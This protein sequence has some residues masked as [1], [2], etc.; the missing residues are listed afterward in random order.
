MLRQ[1]VLKYINIFF[2]FCNTLDGDSS[3]GVAG[4]DVD[5]DVLGGEDR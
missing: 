1:R 4:A 2:N 5:A 3:D